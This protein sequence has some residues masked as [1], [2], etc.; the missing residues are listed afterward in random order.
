MYLKPSTA[1]PFAGLYVKDHAVVPLNK[2]YTQYNWK[3]RW[4]A[5]TIG[6]VYSQGSQL[7]GVPNVAAPLRC[8]TAKNQFQKRTPPHPDDAV[9]ARIGDGD[10]EEGRVHPLGHR[11]PV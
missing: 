11:G 8:S 3:S 6:T 9:A 10:D 1:R 4:S 5:S 7:Y 2:Y